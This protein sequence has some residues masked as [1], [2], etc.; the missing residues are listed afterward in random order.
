MGIQS[1]PIPAPPADA[2]TSA[3]EAPAAIERQIG[4][5]R[6]SSLYA[7][8]E[9]MLFGGFAFTV[10]T[11]VL[12]AS[13][14]PRLLLATWLAIKIA[15]TAARLV[16]GRLFLRDRHRSLRQRHWKSRFVA[17]VVLDSV[18]WGLLSALCMP[19][20]DPAINGVLLAALVAV[21]SAG[22]IALSAD[23]L[24]SGLSMVLVLGPLVEQQALTPTLLA[25]YTAAGLVIYGALLFVEARNSHR[26]FTEAMRLRFENAAIAEE[27]RRA[28]VY[29]E[30]S[31][32]AKTRFLASV[33][34]EL[35]TPLNGIIGMTQLVAVETLSTLQRQRLDVLR[36][37]AEHL[38]NVIGDLLD[39]SRIEFDRIELNAQPT[40]IAQTVRDVTDLL[41]PVA[42]ER[43]LAFEVIFDLGLPA[44]ALMDASRVKQV[45]HNLIG[46]ALKF[47]ARG[48]V[49]VAVAMSDGLLR[50]RVSDTGEGIPPEAIER[51][52][53]AFEQGPSSTAPARSGAGLGLTIS[54]RLARAMGGDVTCRSVPGVGTT[55]EFTIAFRPTPRTPT[56]RPSLS[57]E[58]A[59]AGEAS[60]EP[61]ARV[62]RV[63]VVEDN[64]VNALVV[65]GMLEQMGVDA[66]LAV[67]GEQALARMGAAA[68]DL[69]FMDC[70]MPVLDGWEATRLWRAR[71]TRLRQKQRLP[72]VALTASAA[73]GERERCLEAGMD[74]YLSKPFSREA[75]GELVDRYLAV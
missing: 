74:D 16:D 75:L 63:L 1:S 26:R 6:L 38:V 28:L 18:S 13:S 12:L 49:G 64:E 68:F 59:A 61:V 58:L 69:V 22:A 45:L 41:Q 9:P 70:Q 71:E 42:E 60:A 17:G 20:A 31:N 54:R 47:T 29:A 73:A 5:E 48:G 57:E 33:S 36:H 14:V 2:G 43:D 62:G 56:P 25:R 32:A 53:D 10:V 34:H 30:H 40:L 65:R 52:F 23:R 55:F 4:F 7:I 37:S 11:G 27:R 46:N 19:T 39:L 3:R 67:D 24:T 50:F 15:L 72:I 66:E 44:A 51:I 35:R 8:T 21:A